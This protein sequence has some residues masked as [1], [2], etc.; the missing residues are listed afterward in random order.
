M[1]AGRSIETFLAFVCAAYLLALLPGPNMVFLT[2]TSLARGRRVAWLSALGVETATVIFAILTAAGVSAV[3]AASALLFQVIKWAGV[4]YLVW[5]GISAW[6]NGSG[7]TDDARRR[8]SGAPFLTGFLV[9]ITNPK[10][11]I[12]FLA[13]LPQF[14]NPDASAWPQLLLLGVTL[15]LVGLSCD[16]LFCVAASA[17]KRVASGRRT[18]AALRKIPAI[19][20]FGLAGWAALSAQR[21]A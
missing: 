18:P 15:A 12:F 16:A 2:V 17:L 9:G 21:A 5:L 20:F 6:R 7:G 8:T 4:A 19:A 3:I 13:F 1:I 14:V 10:V 11:I